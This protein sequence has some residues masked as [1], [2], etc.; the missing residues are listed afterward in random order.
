MYCTHLHFGQ[1]Q[2]RHFTDVQAVL[3]QAS[4]FF[5]TK[6]EKFVDDTPL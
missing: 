1:V 6:V 2:S 4:F 5:A 3:L